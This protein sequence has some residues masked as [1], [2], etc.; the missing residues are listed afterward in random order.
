MKNDV[1]TTASDTALAERSKSMLNSRPEAFTI[2]LFAVFIVGGIALYLARP[3]SVS[4]SVTVRCER[5]AV[6]E[7][8]EKRNFRKEQKLAFERCMDESLQTRKKPAS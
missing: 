5:A 2:A 1:N 4:E 3:I 6:I 8:G 7:A